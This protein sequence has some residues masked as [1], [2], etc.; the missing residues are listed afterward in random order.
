METL[1]DA[2]NSKMQLRIDDIKACDDVNTLHDWFELQNSEAVAIKCFIQ[3]LD[4]ADIDDESWFRRAGGALAFRMINVKWLER[5]IISLGETPRYWPSDPRAK[6]L[7]R[8]N[9]QVR[10][11]KKRVVM[12][13]HLEKEN[14]E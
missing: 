1:E 14:I 10:S 3:A 12:L 11:L 8:L 7:A 5:K 9:E 6:E 13:E 2:L 4:E